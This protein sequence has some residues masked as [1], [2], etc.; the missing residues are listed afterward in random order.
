[1]QLSLRAPGAQLQG[2]FC[3]EVSHASEP[4]TEGG[5]AGHLPFCSGSGLLQAPSPSQPLLLLQAECGGLEARSHQQGEGG[6]VARGL[7]RDPVRH[8]HHQQQ[9]QLIR[10]RRLR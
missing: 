5:L 10:A 7:V 9:P 4:R 2:E 8:M 3:E 6:R 1:M